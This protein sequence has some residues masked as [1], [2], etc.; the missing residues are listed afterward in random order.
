MAVRV[1]FVED[2]QDDVEL[3]LRRLRAGGLE[4][5][6]ERVQT[7][8]EL[9]MALADGSWQIALVDY[10]LPGF[11]GVDAVRLIAELA[12]DVPAIT[13]SGSV[14]ED[15][16]VA[17][18]SAGAVDYVLKENLT[19]LA[20]S[21]QRALGGAALR[22]AHR[23]A[24]EDAR[25]ALFALDHASLA[26]MTTGS[27]GTVVYVN[28]HACEVFD[29]ARG[30]LLGRKVWEVEGRNSSATWEQVYREVRERGFSEYR[31][32]LRRRDGSRL[33]LDVT[34]NYLEAEDLTIGYGRDVTRRVEAE[35]LARENEVRVRASEELFR[36]LAEQVPGSVSI[37]DAGLRYVYLNSAW[38]PIGRGGEEV[39]RGKLPEEVL[40]PEEAAA[41]RAAAE[42]ALAGETVDEIIVMRRGDTRKYL[43]S[44]HFPIPR[45]VE[46]LAGGL[47]IDVTPQ[48][49]AQ[50]EARR[51]AERLRRAVEGTVLAMSQVVETR[52]PYTAGHE[53]RVSELATALG[54]KMGLAGAE[55][56][57]LRLGALIHDIGKISVPA[58]IL[59]KPGRLSPEE[60]NLIKQHPQAG[61]DILSIIDFGRPVAELVLQHHERPDGSGYPQGLQAA[62]LLPETHIL[63]VADV[64]EA[65]SSHRPYRPAL[66][67]EV[68]LDE[69]RAGAGTR[70]D[71][72]VAAACERLIVED[73]FTF[74]P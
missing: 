26:V 49:E 29:C 67:M 39:W 18:I 2:S 66:G 65:M 27:D 71:P 42:R 41:I 70:Y 14:N 5:E 45:G 53:R 69:I 73:G 25:L 32:E 40:V 52:D 72:D 16:A 13:V 35:E 37:A 58:E 57:G 56:E 11:S 8:E 4:P 62:D 46:T 17:T 38:D 1:L 74:T 59:A 6:W 61:Y 24:A 15:V 22:R 50:E 64:V 19:R 34:A 12:P 33:V 60:L 55:L 28:D 44:L 48:V 63:G 47:L 23:R 21:V 10:G 9:R 20:P 30:G 7:E 43:H 54:Q 51:Q 36:R 3:M 68:T 31:T